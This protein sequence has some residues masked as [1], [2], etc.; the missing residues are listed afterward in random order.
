[1]KVFISWSG[2]RSKAVAEAL[3]E[4]LPN[5]IQAVRPFMS[6]NDIEKGTRWRS[7]LAEELEQASVSIICLTPENLEAPWIL[8]EA[9]ALSKQQKN[10]Y[11]C[12]FLLGLDPVDVREPLAQFQ[13]TK[14]QRDDVEKLI[15][16]IN[17]ACIETGLSEGKLRE[18]FEIW[19]PRLEI[20]LNNIPTPSNELRQ[21]REPSEVLEEILE[22]VRNLSRIDRP[23]TFKAKSSP[24]LITTINWNPED[25]QMLTEHINEAMKHN[26]Y[27][28]GDENIQRHLSTLKVNRD[29][30][31]KTLQ[32]LKHNQPPIDITDCVTRLLKEF[33]D[34]IPF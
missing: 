9:G 13:A 23:S 29:Y 11:V 30:A 34:D 6:A 7:G 22:I 31:A 4:W 27:L 17:R 12:T 15:Q 24:R 10:S 1:M 3:H 32:Y 25:A 26:D 18:A 20:Q 21:L 8:F 5:V 16:T 19:W 2:E 33:D 14:A 28:F